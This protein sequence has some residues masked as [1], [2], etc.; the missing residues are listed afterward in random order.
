MAA[1]GQGLRLGRGRGRGC[2]GAASGKPLTSLAGPRARETA[3]SSP[4]QRGNKSRRLPS[5]SPR[6]G[7]GRG[8]PAPD[9]RALPAA[10]GPVPQ[11]GP[12]CPGRQCGAGAGAGHAGVAAVSRRVPPPPTGEVRQ[13]AVTHNYSGVCSCV[14]FFLVGL[15]LLFIYSPL[16]ELCTTLF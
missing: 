12:V 13:S 16:L 11:P 5:A 10:A 3:G 2:G 7:T 6:P 9:R 4:A 15:V 1:A 8:R 14:G